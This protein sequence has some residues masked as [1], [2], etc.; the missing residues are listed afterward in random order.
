MKNANRSK[1]EPKLL[2]Y[3]TFLY[4]SSQ[5]TTDRNHVTRYQSTVSS[6]TG[7]SVCLYTVYITRN[8]MSERHELVFNLLMVLTTDRPASL[9]VIS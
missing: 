7:G 2:G 8:L 5:L 3:L 9:T 1:L 6:D 4:I